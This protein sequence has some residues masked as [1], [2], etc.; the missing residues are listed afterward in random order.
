MSWGFALSAGVGECL[1]CGTAA[2]FDAGAGGREKCSC[3]T[4]HGEDCSGVFRRVIA[5]TLGVQREGGGEESQ[6]EEQKGG[7]LHGWFSVL[8]KVP[9]GVSLATKEALDFFCLYHLSC[10]ALFHSVSGRRE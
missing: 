9:V 4:D 6:A 10:T 2:G 1:L 8:G 3:G 7:F 5:S